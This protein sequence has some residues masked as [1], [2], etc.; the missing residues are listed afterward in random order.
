M[1]GV[2]FLQ[3][4][5]ASLPLSLHCIILAEHNLVK[6]YSVPA[7]R[8][9]D[10]TW[11][12]YSAMLA[13]LILCSW[14]PI[15]S[16][17]WVC[18]IIPPCIPSWFTSFYSTLWLFHTFSSFLN[19][20]T[21]PSPSPSQLL[22][23]LSPSLRGWSSQRR[24]STLSHHSHQPSFRLQRPHPDFLLKG[25]VPAASK[26]K[27]FLKLSTNF[28]FLYFIDQDCVIAFLTKME[29]GKWKFTFLC[30]CNI[31]CKGP[32]VGISCWIRQVILSATNSLIPQDSFMTATWF[33]VFNTFFLLE[34]PSLIKVW[35]PHRHCC[36]KWINV[37]QL[38]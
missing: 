1:S 12:K 25:A 6:S 19:S 5:S 16:R 23:L 11:E 37:F 14:P 17:S 21:P 20:T 33:P 13:S 30:F 38:S 2:T 27:V 24:N 29:I 22:A 7:C 32:G 28:H 3:R 36:P 18:P 9:K 10:K 8:P 34:V 31:T 15:S 35:G 26:I 4:P